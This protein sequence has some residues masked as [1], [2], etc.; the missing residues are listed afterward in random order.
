MQVVSLVISML[1]SIIQSNIISSQYAVLRNL[2]K[3]TVSFPNENSKATLNLNTYL[4]FTFFARSSLRADINDTLYD[5]STVYLIKN[6]SSFRYE[7]QIRFDDKFSINAPF[8]LSR[9]TVRYEAEGIGL[10]YRF[11][12]ESYSFIHQLYNNKHIDHLLFAFSVTG[13]GNVGTFYL[14]GIPNQDLSVY[15][16]KGMCKVNDNYNEWSCKF[17]KMSFG[18]SSAQVNSP[19]MFLSTFRSFFTSDILFDF[20]VD[21]V[22]KDSKSICQER[23]TTESYLRYLKC[24]KEIMKNENIVVFEFDTVKIEVKVKEM[25]EE[26]MGSYLSLFESNP[27]PLFKGQTIFGIH[28]IN[29]FNYTIF[30]Y[31][32][33]KISFYSNIRSIKSIATDTTYPQFIVMCVIFL[34]CFSNILLIAYQNKYLFN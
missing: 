31:E 5:N 26:F 15:K 7:S 21:E 16:D 28:F 33:K 12:D 29:I 14:G 10:A 1:F 3:I 32:S 20:M 22:L 13:N 24:T 9:N 17:S 6:Y 23:Q 11:E 19:G 2:P 30:D 4:Q 34:L 8:Y 27:Y 18:S 25:F